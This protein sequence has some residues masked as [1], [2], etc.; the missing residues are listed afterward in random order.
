MNNNKPLLRTNKFLR[1]K[2]SREQMLVEHAAASARI[3]RV[4]NARRIAKEVSRNGS[5]HRPTKRS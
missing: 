1:N 4:P 2:E 3:E 5:L